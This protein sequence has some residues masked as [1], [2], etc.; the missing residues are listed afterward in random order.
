MS[1]GQISVDGIRGLVNTHMPSW[2]TLEVMAD[3]LARYMWALCC[4]STVQF[5][6]SRFA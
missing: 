3:L 5:T 6:D 1:N 2:T 4:L